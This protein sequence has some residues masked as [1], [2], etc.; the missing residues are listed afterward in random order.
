ML[1]GFVGDRD[2]AEAAKDGDEV[3]AGEGFVF[4]C[5]FATGNRTNTEGF[6]FGEDWVSSELRREADRYGIIGA[7]WGVL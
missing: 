5:A 2:A 6:M 7:R 4:V 1:G 3:G